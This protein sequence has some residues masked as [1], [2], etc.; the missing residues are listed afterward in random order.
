MAACCLT[1]ATANGGD[2]QNA[3]I[4]AIIERDFMP[5]VPVPTEASSTSR[6]FTFADGVGDVGF[7]NPVSQPFCGTCNRIRLTAD[8]QLYLL[9]LDHDNADPYNEAK[10]M[11][12]KTVQ[13]T[14][15]V[16][17]RNGMKA[18]DVSAIKAVQ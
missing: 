5:L 1:R 16:L 8:G 13:V 17:A 12:A 15:M 18:I 2:P 3:E 14:G 10:G 6:L 7:I 11:A 9:T 4:K